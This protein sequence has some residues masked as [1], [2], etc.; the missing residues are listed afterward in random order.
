MKKKHEM[1][2]GKILVRINKKEKSAMFEKEI[3]CDDGTTVNLITSIEASENSE[4]Q[5]TQSIHAGDVIAVAGDIDWIKVGD[6]AMLDYIADVDGDVVAYKDI[7]K[8]K[9]ICIEVNAKYHDSDFLIPADRNRSYDKYLFKKGDLDTS[10]M[11]IAIMRDGVLIPNFPYVILA[12]RNLKSIVSQAGIMTIEVEETVIER[13]VIATHSRSRLKVGDHVIIEAESMFDRKT[14]GKMV[15]VVFEHDVL[16]T[17]VTEVN[18][19]ET[20]D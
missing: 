4:A 10:S 16:A 20:L 1:N 7:N 17:V 6:R 11:L 3:H 13:V 15:S 8:D 5:Y 14:D 18:L 2:P 19:I 9:Y 12:Y